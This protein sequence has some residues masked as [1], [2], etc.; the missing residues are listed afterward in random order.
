VGLGVKGVVKK[1]IKAWF[2]N[3]NG[4]FDNETSFFT[5]DTNRF[6][7]YFVWDKNLNVVQYFKW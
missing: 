7:Q 1:F 3:K 5:I 4:W 6:G 2:K